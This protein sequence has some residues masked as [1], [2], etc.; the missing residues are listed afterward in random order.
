MIVLIILSYIL[1]FA[2]AGFFIALLV[3]LYKIAKRKPYKGEKQKISVIVAA[4]N[5][6]KNIASLLDS[7]LLQNYP[8]EKFEVIVANDRSTD[9]TLDILSRYSVTNFGLI[10]YVPVETQKPGLIGKKNALTEAIR[11]SENEILA[12]T[13]ADCTPDP[14]WLNKINEAFTED[15]DFV[16]GYSP[17]QL[18]SK[19]NQDIKNLERAFFFGIAAGSFGLNIPITVTG[20]NMAYRKRLFTKVNGFQGIGT[21]RSGDDD[22][23]M[24]K[25]S[26]HIR[27]YGY[28]LGEEGTVPSKDRSSIDDQVNLETRRYSKLKHH[29]QYIQI[30]SISIFAYFLLLLIDTIMLIMGLMSFDIWYQFIIIKCLSEILFITNYLGFI[31]KTKLLVTYPILG[32]YYIF[33]FIWFGIKGTFGNYKWK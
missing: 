2:Y 8:K 17:L 4:R 22:L 9:K 31:G 13:D 19:F 1:S 25:L 14:E 7:L 27:N 3:G 28:L 33:H 16:G 32:V 21:I 6:E 5:E 23:M 29:P 26:P 18:D 10:K 15:V 24:F 11:L 12:F 30:L 20:R